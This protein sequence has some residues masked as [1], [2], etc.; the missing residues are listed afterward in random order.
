VENKD[1]RQKMIMESEMVKRVKKRV[2]I[3]ITVQGGKKCLKRVERG[4]MG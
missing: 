4:E 3:E 2:G 1:E